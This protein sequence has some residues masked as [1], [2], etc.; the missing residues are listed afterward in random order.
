MNREQWKPKVGDK[1]K[2]T[3]YCVIGSS[4]KH[5]E[6]E[7]HHVE[8]IH[9]RCVTL[10]TLGA[11]NLWCTDIRNL[12]PVR[13]DERTGKPRPPIQE[14]EEVVI[15]LRGF[16]RGTEAVY[17]PETEGRWYDRGDGLHYRRS[18][19]LEVRQIERRKEDRG[20]E[21]RKA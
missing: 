17:L 2:V 20:R 11:R 10:A 6:E 18:E 7:V 3:G 1:V 4:W 21:A 13:E 8:S 9:G 16:T 19:L 15:S 5:A 12:D 14:G